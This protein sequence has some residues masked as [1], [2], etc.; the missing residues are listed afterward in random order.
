MRI[1]SLYLRNFRN[2]R[3]AQFLFAPELNLIVGPNASGKTN[4][5]EAIYF[6]ATGKSFRVK[7]V[8]REAIAYD[9][10]FAQIEGKVLDGEDFELKILLTGG[11]VG[12][13]KVAKKKYFVNGVGK[14]AMDFVGR[15]KAVCFGPEDLELV[16]DSPGLRRKYLDLVLEQ[17]DREYSR[18]LLSYEKGLKQR[19]KLLEEMKETGI[20][21]RRRLYFWDQLLIKNG[22]VITRKREEFLNF[23]NYKQFAVLGV[24][25]KVEYERSAISEER[26]AKYA[27]EEIEAGATLVGP[28]RDDFRFEI[29]KEEEKGR[30]LSLYGSRG[31]QRLAVFWLKLGEMFFVEEKTGEMPVLLLDDIFSE[32]DVE[33]RGLILELAVGKQVLVTT[34]DLGMV[35][36]AWRGK[37]RIIEIGK[38]N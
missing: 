7:G 27:R 38:Q 20:V 35:E 24:K 10:E 2:Y 11:E 5:L 3:E 1:Q 17:V 15:L 16:T 36:E 4:I 22:N 30:D 6:L 26:L 19:N 12:G 9:Q 23:L 32:L 8:E 33:H 29:G 34:A 18:C 14:R 28:H 13:E 37:M 25:F 21:E 31:E